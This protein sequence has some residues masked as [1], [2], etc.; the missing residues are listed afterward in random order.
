[1]AAAGRSAGGGGESP[2]HAGS[3]VDRL[4][5][6]GP[7]RAARLAALGLDTVG[8]VL[9]HLPSRYQDR[10]RILPL[11]GLPQRG[12][13]VVRARILRIA[14]ER[15]GRGRSL[16][17]V[18]LRDASG[19]GA[20][21]FYNQ[22]YRREA[23]PV[24]GEVLLAGAVTRRQGEP[25]L[26]NPDVAPPGGAEAIGVGRLHPVYPGTADLAPSVLRRIVQDAVR[27][28]G[29][30]LEPLALP[31]TDPAG[32]PW[33]DR[34]AALRIC[35]F[36]DDPEALRRA[37]LRFRFEELFQLQLALARRRA[38]FRRAAADDVV[39]VDPSAL[40]A[41]VARLP[42]ELTAGQSTALRTVAADLA[43]VAP[44]YRLL[45]GDVGCGK[46]AVALLAAGLV[47]RSGYQCAFMAPTE[48]LAEQVHAAARALLVGAGV[49]V[50]L[51]VGG[52]EAAARRETLQAVREEAARLVVG[53]HAMIGAG[54]RFGRLGL[55]IVDEEHRFGVEQRERLRGKGPRP[56]VL[57]MS[58]TP[59]PRTLALTAY[60][61]LDRTVIPDRPAGRAVPRTV[62]VPPGRREGALRFV[63]QRLEAGGRGFVVCPAIDAEDRP[64]GSAVRAREALV[65]GPLAGIPVAL[66]HGRLAPA[67]RRA[68]VDGLRRGAIRL[69]V[70]TS[71]VEVGVDVPEA[72]VMVVQSP[73]RF[74]LAQL[75][76][77]RGR[78]GRGGQPAHCLLLLDGTE[79]RAARSRLEALCRATSGFVLA[80][81]DL[82]LRGPGELLGVRQHGLPR[83]KLADPRRDVALLARARRE[84]F[85]R[86]DLAAAPEATAAALSP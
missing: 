4:A 9:L 5:G 80:E 55:V 38:G 28:H 42:F 54:V 60:G 52:L 74:G 44:M 39:R 63:R 29:D 12:T 3:P 68:V 61:D 34:A 83:L 81:V 71:V 27:A 67:D 16:L 22:P 70:A 23:L 26:L 75:H 73:G 51:L 65:A 18:A 82:E 37:R 45:H 17:R 21:V 78:V 32:Q 84:A 50:R 72:D 14:L 40:G 7:R 15:R 24:G 20:A 79:T 57:V 85:A 30:L 33:L 36:P 77:L 19:T 49:D 76:Q 46:T 58:A 8:D 86:V 35:H 48:L 11:V 10:R 62:I 53:T 6:V 2:I 56:H 69:L 31:G 13:G 47:V 64:E 59:I 1:M 66:L 41:L 25:C 43:G